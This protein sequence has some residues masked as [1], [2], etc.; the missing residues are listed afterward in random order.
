LPF[1][2]VHFLLKSLFAFFIDFSEVTLHELYVCIF[3]LF[4]VWDY[5]VTIRHYT[6]ISKMLRQLRTETFVSSE[7][8]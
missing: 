8:V 3:N 5:R 4:Y 1:I 2:F 6:D 7:I